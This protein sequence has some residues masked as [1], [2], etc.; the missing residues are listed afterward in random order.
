MTI[1]RVALLLT[2][3]AAAGGCAARVPSPE[4]VPVDRAECAYCRMLISTDR[5]AA[6]VVPADG[7]TRFYDD[8]GC[9][10]ADWRAH[11]ASARAFVRTYS[12]PW[13]D[14]AS[15]VYAKPPGART[16]MGSG[17]VAFATA[18]DAQASSAGGVMTFDQV[19]QS[20]GA[21]Q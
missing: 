14:A 1:K 9:L 17:F 7:D 19:L 20:G 18:A 15:A 12:G 11:A 16:A 3:I 8:V 13:V 5:G 4:P 6:E 2:A 10:A 21:G